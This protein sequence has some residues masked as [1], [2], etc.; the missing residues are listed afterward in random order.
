MAVLGSSGSGK[1]SLTQS[2]V[3]AFARDA[4]IT[5]VDQKRDYY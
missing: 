4:D 1:T 2:I 5:V 3:T